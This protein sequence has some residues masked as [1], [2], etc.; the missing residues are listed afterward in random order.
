MITTELSARL[1]LAKEK[2]AERYVGVCEQPRGLVV[3]ASGY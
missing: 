2:H 1:E 3:R